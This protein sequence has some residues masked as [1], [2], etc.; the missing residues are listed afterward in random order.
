ME[1][2][3]AAQA[4]SPTQQRA[5]RM[6]TILSLVS[7]IV[8]NVILPVLI[9]WALTTYTHIPSLLALGASGVPSII[10][11]IV[12]II[13]RKR[14]DLLGGFVLVSIGISIILVALGGSDKI[15]LIRE[16]FFT[17]AFGLAYLVSLLFPR[18]IAFYVARY[19]VTGNHPENILWFDSLWH[20]QQF[21]HT[22]R[23]IT[24]VW[25]IGFL[26]EAAIRTYLVLTLS[27]VQ[28]L[29]VSP[30]VLWGIIVGLIVWMFLYSR[31]GRK[32]G[33][34]LRLRMQAEQNATPAQ[35]AS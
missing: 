14:I 13:R 28:F 3:V 22:M 27:T 31:E 7:S 24:V 15:Y 10:D 18:P 1:N 2:I 19:F 20:S 33:E 16:S 17:A 32:K 26:L 29:I 34:A 6:A 21:R 25:G 23:V 12:G 30:F 8:I 4:D 9:Y 35:D 11:S 5:S